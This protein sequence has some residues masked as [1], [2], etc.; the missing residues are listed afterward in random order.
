[1]R[2][3]CL[4]CEHT[5]S[6]PPEVAGQV[7]KCPKCKKPVAVPE[8][9]SIARFLLAVIISA[10]LIGAIGFGLGVLSSRHS[11]NETQANLTAMQGEVE[12]KTAQLREAHQK[13]I[14]L[15]NEIKRLQAQV[16]E[17][18]YEQYKTQEAREK[19]N[20][21]KRKEQE[22][23]KARVD[24]RK[25]GFDNFARGVP[26]KGKVKRLDEPVLG[27]YGALVGPLTRAIQ[28]V[29]DDEVIV[30]PPFLDTMRGTQINQARTEYLLN[31]I[32]EK[33]FAHIAT[34]PPLAREKLHLNPS[35]DYKPILLKGFPTRGMVDNEL[36][37][38]KGQP[39][40]NPEIA[41]ISTYT[42]ITPSGRT[43]TVPLAI[44]L[45]FIRQGLTVG[46]LEQLS[47]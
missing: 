5:F 6:I 17:L 37:W 8:T 26:P 39:R 16:Q 41:I 28:V 33:G 15:T 1:M 25:L 20:L 9:R 18:K 43:N 2:A 44:P 10:A 29:G 14:Q 32:L 31:I 19:A 27:S 34:L 35:L 40:G 23:K 13:I 22:R 30:T 12:Q 7:V 24:W 47:K 3:I 46:E 36:W 11:K 4:N 38:T 21:E 42:Y 45:D